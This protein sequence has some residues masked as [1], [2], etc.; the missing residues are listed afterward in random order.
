MARGAEKGKGGMGKAETWISGDCSAQVLCRL[1]QRRAIADRA[2]PI[3][4]HEF[5]IGER[6][7]AVAGTS[8]DR[9]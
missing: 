4:A 8:F 7:V 2:E 9:G 5:R 3:A 6:I 1:V